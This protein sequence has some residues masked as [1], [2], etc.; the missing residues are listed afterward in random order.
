[1]NKVLRDQALQLTPDERLELIGDL[2]DSLDQRDL[3]PLSDDQIQ[4]MKRRLA[5]HRA[6]PGEARSWE[7]VKAEIRSRLR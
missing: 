4:E 3:P 5:E 7:E 1:M 6:N 2:W